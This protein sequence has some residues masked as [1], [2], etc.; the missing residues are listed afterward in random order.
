MTGY[1]HTCFCLLGDICRPVGCGPGRMGQDAVRYV[2]RSTFLST[3][4]N[5]GW[6]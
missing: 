3:S 2:E 5:L 4:T 1:I 6:E